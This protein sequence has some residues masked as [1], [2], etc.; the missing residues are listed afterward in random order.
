MKLFLL[1]INPCNSLKDCNGLIES[2]QFEEKYGRLGQKPAQ[3]CSN[4][5]EDI[6]DENDPEPVLGN[7][8]EVDDHKLVRQCIDDCEYD[9]SRC[10]VL[11][12][13]KFEEVNEAGDLPD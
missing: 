6:G 2:I 3:N 12:R 4:Y 13:Q 1:L 7:L 11:E 8:P 5:L 10:S 9:C